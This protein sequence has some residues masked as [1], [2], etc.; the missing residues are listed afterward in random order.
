[1]NILRRHFLAQI[2]K[3]RLLSAHQTA[4]FAVDKLQLLGD[5]APVDTRRYAA[6]AGQFAQTGD[7]HRIK[8]VQIGCGNRQES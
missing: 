4:R 3:N 5:A 2:A 1:M 8:F 6:R 7:A